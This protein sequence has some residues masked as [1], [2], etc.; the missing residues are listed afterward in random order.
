MLYVVLRSDELKF[1]DG[2]KCLNMIKH[3]YTFGIP[4]LL[5]CKCY[6]GYLHNINVIRLWGLAHDIQKNCLLPFAI[7]KGISS[8]THV[9]AGGSLDI[10]PSHPQPPIWTENAA[11]NLFL[12][13][14]DWKRHPAPP[15]PHNVMTSLF[16]WHAKNVSYNISGRFHGNY[17]IHFI[18]MIQYVSL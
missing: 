14:L 16:F 5:K 1:V 7:F 13:L 8:I 9:E 17:H 6:H 2:A 4:C 12:L 3:D 11:S 15:P 10:S 18:F